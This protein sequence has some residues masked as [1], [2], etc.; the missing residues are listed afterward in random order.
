MLSAR[1]SPSYYNNT[2]EEV[3]VRANTDVVIEY[4]N[5]RTSAGVGVMG[6]MIRGADV[7]TAIAL[8]NVARSTEGCPPN[9]KFCEMG[10]VKRACR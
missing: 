2:K 4:F 7:Q 10:S 1:F 5:V 9:R 3:T 8:A 6:L